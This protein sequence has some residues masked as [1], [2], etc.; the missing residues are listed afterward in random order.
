MSKSYRIAIAVIGLASFGVVLFLLTRPPHK[1]VAFIHICASEPGRV[2]NKGI[3]PFAAVVPRLKWDAGQTIRCR[4]LSGDHFI[5]SK[6]ETFAH[7]WEKY[8]NIHFVFS[9]DPDAEIRI[10]INDNGQ[11]NSYI[12]TEALLIDPTERTMN[13][14]WFTDTTGDDEF[15]RTV[16]HEFGHALGLIHEHQSPAG[17]IH[18]NR[19]AILAA[20]AQDGPPWNDPAFVDSN[21]IAKYTRD[22]T[23]YTRLDPK[24]IM[25][26][27]IPDSFTTDHFSVGWNDYLSQTDEAFIHQ[28]YP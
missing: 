11:S 9:Q 4:F 22:A 27:P 5:Q 16:L 13:F 28:Q 25:M 2:Q 10:D 6:I 23:Q 21:V 17:G 26:Y 12:G 19:P 15:S 8:A 20:Y 7:Q 3:R 24:S 14:G 18:W 1:P